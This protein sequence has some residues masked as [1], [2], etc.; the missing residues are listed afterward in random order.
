MGGDRIPGPLDDAVDEE[1]RR[2]ELLRGKAEA[3]ELGD[4]LLRARDSWV[5]EFGRLDEIALATINTPGQSPFIIKYAQAWLAGDIYNKRL[6]VP[7]FKAFIRN[8]GLDGL[9]EDPRQKD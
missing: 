7:V 3:K 5:A 6:M 8:A 4:A 9:P 2:R 1:T